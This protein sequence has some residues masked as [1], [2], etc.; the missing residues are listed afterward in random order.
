[1]II[2]RYTKKARSLYQLL[3]PHLEAVGIAHWN[4]NEQP[5][6]PTPIWINLPSFLP[7]RENHTANISTSFGGEQQTVSWGMVISY[8]WA[9][10]VAMSSD[11]NFDKF[12]TLSR[13]LRDRARDK[14]LF[15]ICNPFIAAYVRHIGRAFPCVAQADTFGVRDVA[16]L[17]I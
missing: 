4:Q 12:P 1:M 15:H 3:A 11:F 14:R 2:C 17:H 7:M 8:P 6:T 10:I 5:K 13:C 9:S 16:N